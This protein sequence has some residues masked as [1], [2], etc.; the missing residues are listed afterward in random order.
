MRIFAL[1]VAALATLVGLFALSAWL[2]VAALASGVVYV[3][4]RIN[5]Q[6]SES[7]VRLHLYQ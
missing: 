6:P 1:R 7:N 2:G 3:A 5:R 4:W